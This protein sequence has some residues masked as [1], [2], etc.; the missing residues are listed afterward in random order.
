MAQGDRRHDRLDAPTR[1]G[2]PSYV[3]GVV[4]LRD[5]RHQVAD[6]LPRGPG[7]GAE[8]TRTQQCRARHARPPETMVSLE[9]RAIPTV[10][11]RTRRF[12]RLWRF[13]STRLPE[14]VAPRTPRAR[15]PHGAP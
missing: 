8:A 1:R 4:V 5:A 11:D 6:G 9:R 10:P 14:L 15:D 13:R 3:H 2:G 12:P 7:P